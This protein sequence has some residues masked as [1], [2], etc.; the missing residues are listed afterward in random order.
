MSTGV[1]HF[2]FFLVQEG[3]DGDEPAAVRLPAPAGGIIFRHR[4]LRMSLEIQIVLYQTVL[5]PYCDAY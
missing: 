2:R 3:L 1:S 5:T 4:D